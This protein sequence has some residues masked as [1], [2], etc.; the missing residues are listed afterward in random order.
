MK[1][2]PSADASDEVCLRCALLGRYLEDWSWTSSSETKKSL[3]KSL[4]D[5]KSKAPFD[6]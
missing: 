3:S 6:G 1:E 5:L 4:A 2:S